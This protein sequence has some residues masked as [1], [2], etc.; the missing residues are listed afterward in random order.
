MGVNGVSTES[1]TT[2]ALCWGATA[3]PGMYQALFNHDVDRYRA[4]I[5]SIEETVSPNK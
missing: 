2:T 4:A 1:Q 5:F 3:E